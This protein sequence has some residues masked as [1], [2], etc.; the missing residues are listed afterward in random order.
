M[1]NQKRELKLEDLAGYFP[2]GIKGV[3]S[4]KGRL[5]QDD[6][7]PNHRVHEVGIIKN[8]SF[9]GSEITGQLHVSETYSFD[10][11]EID[12]VDILLRPL[13]DLTKEIDHNGE[14]FV[15][16]VELCKIADI[17]IYQEFYDFDITETHIE[18]YTFMQC[19]GYNLEDSCFYY[20]G[21]S[22]EYGMVKNQL[23]LFQKLYEWKLD[24]HGLLEAG[25]AVNLNDIKK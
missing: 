23:Q 18:I 2:Y 7:Y 11:S 17:G 25:L 3:L 16:I 6:D 14:R 15:P 22:D 1:E 13:S 10:F 5:N 4:R 12:E 8:I 21:E 24:I 20:I 9:W 19:F